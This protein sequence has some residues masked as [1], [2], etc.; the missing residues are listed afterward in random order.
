MTAHSKLG[1]SSMERWSACPGSVRLCDSL[2]GTW[3]VYAQEGTDAH[4]VAAG[5]LATGAFPLAM[6]REDGSSFY[7][8]GE[9]KEAVQVYVDHLNNTFERGDVDQVEVR[10]DLSA[11]HPGCFGT[12]DHVRWRAS[13]K[14]LIVTD[15]KHGAGIPVSP[16]ENP[17]LMYYGLGALLAAGYPAH[18]VR[19]VIVQP[20]C[21]IEGEVIREWEIDAIDLVDFKADLRMYALAAEA[22]DAPLVPGGH[23]RFCPAAAM[24][25][26]LVERAQAV[27]KSEFAVAPVGRYDPAKLAAALDMRETVKAWLSALDEFAYAEALAGKCPPGYKLVDKRATR[28]WKDE[29]AAATFLELRSVAEAVMWERKLRS[30]SHLEMLKAIKK[31]EMDADFTVKESSGFVLVPESDKRP[32]VK[33]LTAQQEFAAAGGQTQGE[34]DGSAGLTPAVQTAQTPASG[35]P[36]IPTFLKRKK[37]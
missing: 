14:L 35:E 7:V 3:S 16:V 32:A 13:Q 21:A 4:A 9:M 24:C 8:T 20:R 18:R 26:A 33:M 15:Y 31:G 22:P 10:F 19:L 29:T 25:P 12:A 30:P 28:K 37:G 5:V 11:V 36:E 17:Q 34:A 2:D 6:G 23:C 1:A 27:A